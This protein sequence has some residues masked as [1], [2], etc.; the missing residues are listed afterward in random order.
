MRK[1]SLRVDKPDGDF[2]IMGLDSTSF[3]RAVVEAMQL[4]VDEDCEL[5]LLEHLYE[6]VSTTPHLLK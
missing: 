3:E 1:Y 6:L 2:F 4:E 5:R